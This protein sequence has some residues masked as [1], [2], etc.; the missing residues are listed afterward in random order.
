M[1]I[2]AV[3]KVTESWPLEDQ[4]LLMD[5]LWDRICEEGWQPELSEELKVEVDRRLADADAD[6]NIVVTWDDIVQHV[7]RS[8]QATDGT[9]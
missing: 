9:P 1:D 5:R 3:L 2:P 6:P 7:G 4:M 8:R